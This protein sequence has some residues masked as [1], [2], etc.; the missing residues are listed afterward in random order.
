LRL[1]VYPLYKPMSKVDIGLEINSSLFNTLE[2]TITTYIELS[3]ST[4]AA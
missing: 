4:Y 1:S 3:L 2:T